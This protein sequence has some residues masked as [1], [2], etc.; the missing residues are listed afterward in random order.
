MTVTKN[1]WGWFDFGKSSEHEESLYQNGTR[2]VPEYLIWYRK[3]G[4]KFSETSGQDSV[5]RTEYFDEASAFQYNPE[6]KC[7]NIWWKSSIFETWMSQREIQP[8]LFYCFDMKRNC[9]SRTCLS[10]TTDCFKQPSILPSCF[11]TLAS[12]F[13]INQIFDFAGGF[14]IFTDCLPT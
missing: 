4:K 11:G 1:C 8:T 12:V 6:V 3:S 13:E 5:G 2:I 7:Q 14:Y 9:P 10:K